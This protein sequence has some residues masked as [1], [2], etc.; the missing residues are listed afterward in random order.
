MSR[1]KRLRIWVLQWL[2][3]QQM[4]QHCKAKKLRSGKLLNGVLFIKEW[5]YAI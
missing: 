3:Q 2:R 1:R 4:G 5:T